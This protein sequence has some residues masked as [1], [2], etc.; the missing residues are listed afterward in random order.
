MIEEQIEKLTIIVNEIKDNEL[1]H[2]KTEVAL[3]KQQTKFNTK[4][5][6]IILAS[7]VPIA[8]LLITI[9]VLAA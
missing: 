3:N 9:V 1:P 7:G 5:I 2:I 6:L 8:G 4:L